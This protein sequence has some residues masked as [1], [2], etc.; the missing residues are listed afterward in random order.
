RNR[1]HRRGFG[2]SAR[3]YRRDRGALSDAARLRAAHPARTASHQPGLWS[4]GPHPAAPRSQPDGAVQRRGSGLMVPVLETERLILRG[5][6]LE[7]FAAHAAMWCDE[8]TLRHTGGQPRSEE[9]LWLRFLRNEGQ[10]GL[11]GTGMWALED[12]AS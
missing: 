7:D 8:R 2:R 4:S 6:R 3:R 10:W 11:T 5:H 1:D 9:Q 12:K